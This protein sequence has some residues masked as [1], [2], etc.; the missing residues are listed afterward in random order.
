VRAK[1]RGQGP[2]VPAA[3]PP[4]PPPAAADARGA[5]RSAA[6][7]AIAAIAAA[8]L[9]LGG[10]WWQRTP[11][12]SFLAN[13]DRNI[14]LV[15]IDTLRADALGSY[16]GRAL[17]PNLDRL[18]AHG[19]RFDFA[20]AHAVVTLP[21]H[22]TILTGRYPYHHGIRDTGY[23]LAPGQ[24]TAATLLK[25]L[26]LRR[27]V[28]RRLPARSSIRP[29]RRL[30]QYDR[31]DPAAGGEPGERE[32]R[33]DAVVAAA[34]E[35]MG[36]QPGKW[37]TWVRVYDRATYPATARVGGAVPLRPVSRRGVRT[38]AALGPL[39]ARL[40]SLHGRP[41][42]R[43]GGPRREPWRA[44]RTTRPVRLRIDAARATDVAE[45]DPQQ[46]VRRRGHRVADPVATSTCC[47]R[48][49]TPAAPATV[50]L[51]GASPRPDRRRHRA[52]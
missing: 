27:G 35:W 42:R 13:A 6:R 34:L 41:R 12:F 29:E 25:P 24:P 19:A 10:W 9:A 3:P 17:T 2:R 22:A 16:G 15:T 20:H 48:C 1:S 51:P 7:Y 52:A 39:F 43:H 49:W 50:T 44:R 32:R 46:A 8:V 47:R 4:A 37:F 23:R 14:L 30:D 31:L 38:D 45:I 26:G 11:A 28:R 33:A 21:S 5:H 18:A 36:G 40:T